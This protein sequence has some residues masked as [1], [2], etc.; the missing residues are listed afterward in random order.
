[1]SSLTVT[2]RAYTKEG[3]HR[4]ILVQDEI[5]VRMHDA[6]VK[7][8]VGYEGYGMMIDPKKFPEMERFLV[9]VKP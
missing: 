7:E 5:Q 6:A 3:Y 1:M 9:L 2:I 8:Y 4:D